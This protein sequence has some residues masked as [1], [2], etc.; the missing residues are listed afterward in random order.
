MVVRT[1]DGPEARRVLRAAQERPGAVIEDVVL[2]EALDW[3][4]GRFSEATF[5]RS[6]LVHAR[7]FGGL[8]GRH[9][10][11]RCRF[12]NVSAVQASAFAVAAKLIQFT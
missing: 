12:T 1:L 4:R 3:P 5:R 9:R 11:V 2:P 7:I 8:L 10:F 6:S